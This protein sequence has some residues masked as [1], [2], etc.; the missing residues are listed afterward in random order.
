MENIYVGLALLRKKGWISPVL[1]SGMNIG[2]DM[3]TLYFLFIAAGYAI[4]PGVLLAG[5]GLAFLLGKVAFLFPGGVGVIESGMTAVYVSLGIPNSI[6]VV[7]ILG[8]RL[9]SFWLPSLLGFTVAGY[10]QRR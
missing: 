2:F 3:L 7:V 6:S 1:G 5:Y 9:F 4:N 8:Y 10:L